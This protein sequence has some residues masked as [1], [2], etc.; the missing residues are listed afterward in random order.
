MH[1]DIVKEVA[2]A[3]VKVF[4][5]IVYTEYGVGHDYLTNQELLHLWR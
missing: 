2:I 4:I 5:I 3:S 1:N